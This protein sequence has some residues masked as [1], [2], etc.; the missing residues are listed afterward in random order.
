MRRVEENMMMARVVVV[1][2]GCALVGEGAGYLF[3]A[4]VSMDGSTALGW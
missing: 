2:G 1:V 4:R 3:M